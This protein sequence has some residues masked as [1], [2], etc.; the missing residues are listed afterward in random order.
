MGRGIGI[1][2]LFAAAA[3]AA[4]WGAWPGSPVS[5]GAAAQGGIII[6]LTLLA[7]LPLLTR[8]WL[9][10]PDS[11]AAR[12]LRAGFYAAVLAVL[13]AQA[14]IGMFNGAVPRAG[15]DRHTWGYRPGRRSAGQL[16]RRPQ[17]GRR[18]SDPDLYGLLRGSHPRADRAAHPGGPGH[19]GPG[20]GCGRGP[21]RRDVRGGTARAQLQVPGPAVAARRCDRH[22]HGPGLDPGH[23]RTV[24]RRLPGRTAL[25][26]AGRPGPGRRRTSL[27]GLRRGVVSGGVGA[28]FVTIFGSGTVALLVK[29]AWV[30]DWLY[31][32]QHVTAS[33]VYG[34]ELYASQNVMGYFLLLVGFP[35]IGLLLGL[36]GAGIANVAGTQPDGEAPPDPPGPE[37]MPG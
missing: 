9:G 31:H 34:R 29:S 23:R 24:G 2:V 18:D 17:L 1:L 20:R 11:R 15:I 21:G 8:W 5:H 10:P 32:G 25:P 3:G 30:R 28:L 7:G 27:A 16:N 14:T 37:P 35:F 4:A 22:V 12:W 6:T 33:A 26:G 19:S 36:T 13:P